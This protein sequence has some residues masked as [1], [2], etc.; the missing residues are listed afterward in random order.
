MEKLILA[1]TTKLAE[2]KEKIAK[3]PYYNVVSPFSVVSQFQKSDSRKICF[4]Q[5]VALAKSNSKMSEPD[6]DP[7]YFGK[8]YIS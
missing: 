1:F 7:S 8:F 6:W 3:D 5:G 4:A 2:K